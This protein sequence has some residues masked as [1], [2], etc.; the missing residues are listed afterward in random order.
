MISPQTVFKYP[1][2]MRRGERKC[3]AVFIPAL[4]CSSPSVNVA[5]PWFCG[6]GQ[7]LVDREHLPCQPL[8]NAEQLCLITL[9]YVIPCSHM[10]EETPG[11]CRRRHPPPPPPCLVR[12]IITGHSAL[13]NEAVINPNC[14]KCNW[15]IQGD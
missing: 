12:E 11:C 8:A 2:C 7:M 4:T 13:P 3:Q 5:V 6:P 1:C 10:H 9:N 15:L 14:S